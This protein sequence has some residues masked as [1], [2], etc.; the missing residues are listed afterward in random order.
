MRSSAEIEAAFRAHLAMGYEGSVVR[1]PNGTYE[2]GVRKEVRSKNVIKLKPDYDAEFKIVGYSEGVGQDAGAIV[3]ELECIDAAG[4]PKTFKARPKGSIEG[5][6][7]LFAQ[8]PERFAS[9]YLGKMMTVYY[10]DTT[11]DG[12][13][14]FP[15]AGQVRAVSP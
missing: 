12:I 9:D 2:A 3:W 15:R 1:M 14:R 4:V 7:A 13:P 10:G 8:M 6:R 11:A 5:R